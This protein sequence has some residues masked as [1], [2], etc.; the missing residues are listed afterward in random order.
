MTALVIDKKMPFLLKIAT[1]IANLEDTPE[2]RE[3]RIAGF[4]ADVQA[5]LRAAVKAKALQRTGS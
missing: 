2:G 3:A 1:N 5:R 4:P